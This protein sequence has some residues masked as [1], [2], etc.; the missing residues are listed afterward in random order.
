MTLIFKK[1]FMDSIKQAFYFCASHNASVMF[2]VN[3]KVMKEH[4]LFS[5]LHINHTF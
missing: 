4:R 1:K 5:K 2:D 3:V